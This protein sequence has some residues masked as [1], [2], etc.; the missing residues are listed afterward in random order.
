M[1]F[2]YFQIAFSIREIQILR[3]VETFAGETQ[4]R[5]T[6]HWRHNQHI[7]LLFSVSNVLALLT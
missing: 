3:I 2:W 7:Y 5:L 4:L 6:Q 1:T